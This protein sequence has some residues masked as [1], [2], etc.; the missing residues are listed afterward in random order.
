MNCKLDLLWAVEGGLFPLELVLIINEIGTVL[1]EIFP[2]TF[3]FILG[4]SDGITT[5]SE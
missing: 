1:N 4:V 5:S 3:F 2:F